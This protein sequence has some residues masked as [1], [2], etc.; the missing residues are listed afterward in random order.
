MECRTA[1]SFEVNS[2]S[3]QFFVELIEH[4]EG[5][6][7]APLNG[8]FPELMMKLSPLLSVQDFAQLRA[9]CSQPEALAF[10]QLLQ[11]PCSKRRLFARVERKRSA[12]QWAELAKVNQNKQWNK[13]SK[14]KIVYN[15]LGGKHHFTP[16]G[17]VF[18]GWKEYLLCT[19]IGCCSPDTKPALYEDLV[20]R[21]W[22]KR[23][24]RST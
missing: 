9:A 4:D 12:E 19:S 1:K 20:F 5:V 14:Q 3:N 6:K 15:L 18:D 11:L 24:G 10:Q 23:I 22:P 8:L 7:P 17:S 16:T 2:A 21:D 13:K